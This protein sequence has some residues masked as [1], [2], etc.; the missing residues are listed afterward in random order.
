[1]NYP[2]FH[3][4]GYIGVASPHADR[5][6]DFAHEVLGMETDTTASAVCRVRWDDRPYRLAVHEGPADELLYLG[7]EVGHRGQLARAVRQL[8]AHG[9]LVTK[10]PNELADERSV[11]ELVSFRDPFGLRHEVFAGAVEYDRTFRGA[12]TTSRFRTGPQGLGHAVL[13]IP[14][15]SVGQPFYEDVLGLKTTDMVRLNDP[16]GT[17]AFLRCNTRHHS[18]ALWERPDPQIGLQ[19]IMVES[20]SVD[21]VGRAYD[22]VA[23]GPWEISATLGRHVGDEQMSFYVRSPSGFDVE[24]GCDSIDID[25]N[26]W[27]MRFIDRKAGAPNEVWGHHWQDLGPQTSLHPYTSGDR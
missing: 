20:D 23:R 11:R 8:E 26:N 24:M 5:W 27:T 1:M 14:D 21:D 25:D 6:P 15:L 18:V 19:H 7:W 2:L 3:S 22:A 12:R 17:M 4:L 16:M 10:E 13:V 9:V